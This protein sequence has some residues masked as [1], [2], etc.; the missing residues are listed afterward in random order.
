[1]KSKTVLYIGLILVALGFFVAYG[2]VGSLDNDSITL[3][4]G[5]IGV[6][7]GFA[8]MVCGGYVSHKGGSYVD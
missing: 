3:K 6:S 5:I 2:I 8:L 1:M 7:L 4:D